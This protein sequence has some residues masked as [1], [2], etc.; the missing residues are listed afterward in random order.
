MAVVSQ[1]LMSIITVLL[2]PLLV[3]W[4]VSSW[5]FRDALPYCSRSIR[6]AYIARQ[7]RSSAQVRRLKEA[8][9]NATSYEERTAAATRLDET[10]HGHCTWKYKI[11]SKLYDY[12]YIHRLV[13]ELK[14]GD[15]T[16][17]ILSFRFKIQRSIGRNLAGIANPQLYA[18]LY[19][20]T[21]AV[22]EDY[23]KL[24]VDRI[25][26]VIRYGDVS[27]SKDVSNQW[28]MEFVEH[29]RRNLGRT[30][31][32]LEGG[33]IFAFY[34]VGVMKELYRHGLLPNVILG[35]S[36]GAN[37]AAL[38]AVCTDDELMDL[39]SDSGLNV[40]TLQVDRDKNA[41]EAEPELEWKLLFCSRMSR[42][43]KAVYASDDRFWFNVVETHVGDMTFQEAFNRTRR[44]VSISIPCVS[45]NAPTCLNYI[46]TPNVLVRTAVVAS[47]ATEMD[48]AWYLLLEK[49]HVGELRAYSLNFGISSPPQQRQRGN[50]KRSKSRVG[51]NKSA[52]DTSMRRI[53][54]L[55]AVN[56]FIVA[57]P[58]PYILPF[59]RTEFFNRSQL[60]DEFPRLHAWSRQ[61]FVHLGRR[62]VRY[63]S[64]FYTFPESLQA[65]LTE[66]KTPGMKMVIAPD[67]GIEELE[68]LVLSPSRETIE[69]W[70]SV[71]EKAVWPYVPA[72]RIRCDVELALEEHY[73][74][75]RKQ[76]P[77]FRR[78]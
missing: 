11:E 21:K 61:L 18:H 69:K 5:L 32:V 12:K 30:A 54:Q 40:D 22:I 47:Q 77:S 15:Q 38:A 76:V 44:M 58:R 25:D 48:L 28:K 24:V 56:H 57:Q 64:H 50:V 26:Y 17:N 45:L 20:G 3:V 62:T 52:T 65:L 74:S 19:A 51:N 4:R 33:G 34:H 1:S 2:Y 63:L 14:E 42:L 6:D 27:Q 55:W 37:L 13:T 9:K 49:S 68:N 10:L 75:L 39:L 7:D 29:S 8:L 46:T 72:L 67:D 43:S 78:R 53:S 41:K 66:T 23:V 73:Q 36:T 60:P 35:S 59:I 70:I 16:G 31:L 71:G